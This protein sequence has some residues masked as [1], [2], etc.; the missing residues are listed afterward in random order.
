M[1]KYITTTKVNRTF[2]ELLQETLD[3]NHLRKPEPLTAEQL[4]W[5]T[6]P[7]FPTAHKFAVKGEQWQLVLCALAEERLLDD[8]HDKKREEF[9]P[10]TMK[11]VQWFIQTCCEPHDIYSLFLQFIANAELFDRWE[12]HLLTACADEDVEKATAAL[13]RIWEDYSIFTSVIEEFFVCAKRTVSTIRRYILHHHLP[14]VAA[15]I[16][17]HMHR[18]CFRH[19]SVIQHAAFEQDLDSSSP[20]WKL[21]RMFSII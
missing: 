9:K 17:S 8:D 19:L 16:H 2:L 20:V 12:Q 14:S 18:R 15:C 13:K 7:G 21:K 6:F 1:K 11:R 3:H 10:F 4:A 5:D